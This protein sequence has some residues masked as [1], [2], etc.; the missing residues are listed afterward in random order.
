MKNA[1]HIDEFSAKLHVKKVGAAKIKSNLNRLSQDS[2]RLRD[3]KIIVSFLH[4]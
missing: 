1:K 2:K 4:G 3:C